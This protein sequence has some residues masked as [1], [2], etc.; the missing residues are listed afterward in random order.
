MGELLDFEK[1]FR[2]RMVGRLMEQCGTMNQQAGVVA[3]GYFELMMKDPT[4][5]IQR[6]PEF[7]ERARDIN[8]VR[9]YE[10]MAGGPNQDWIGPL[11]NIVGTVYPALDRTAREQGLRQCMNF[12]DGLNYSYSQ[13]HVELINEPW[14]ASDIVIT[15]PLYWCGYEHYCNVAKQNKSW[16]NFSGTMKSAKS[17]FWLAMAVTHP[18]YAS[19]EVR[20]NFY[21]Q[22]PTLMDR[23]K[24]ALAAMAAV[25]GGRKAEKEGLELEVCIGERLATHDPL[26]HEDI[27]AKIEEKKWIVLKE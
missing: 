8:P 26:L 25:Y 21:E 13:N 3:N 15:R 23:T 7:I 9:G 19:L 6:L 10:S 5:A 27:R 20:K 2:E 24:D 17:A 22:F 12:L 4:K 1:P 16:K 18:E 14:L 11:F